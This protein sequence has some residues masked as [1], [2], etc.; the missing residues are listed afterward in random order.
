MQKCFTLPSF[1][2]QGENFI[3]GFTQESLESNLNNVEIITFTEIIGLYDFLPNVFLL[4]KQCCVYLADL[5][6]WELQIIAL[7]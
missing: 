3:M 2:K 1:R 4:S 7:F 6:Y 5:H